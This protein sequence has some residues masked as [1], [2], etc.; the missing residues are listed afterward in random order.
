MSFS[1]MSISLDDVFCLLHFPIRGVFWIPQDVTKEV[2]VELVVDYLGVSLSEA[3]VHVRSC[4]GSYYKLE[5]LYVLFIHYRV[6]SSW[7][8]ATRAYL[9]M[10]VGSIIFADKTFTL[11][12]ARYLLLITNLGRCPG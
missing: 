9:L 3:H 8:Y 2:V 12:E 10:F 1:E 7:T 5:W 6:A 4:R 11:V